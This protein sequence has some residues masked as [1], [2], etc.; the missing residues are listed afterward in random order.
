[1]RHQLGELDKLAL[2]SRNGSMDPIA[3]IAL[4]KGVHNNNNNKSWHAVF[5][6]FSSFC[7]NAKEAGKI[8]GYQNDGFMTTADA[9]FLL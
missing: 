3:A 9:F 8:T 5:F 7:Y 1:M 6:F 2:R 4:A